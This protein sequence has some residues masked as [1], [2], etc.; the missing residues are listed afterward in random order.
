[1]ATPTN[2]AAA[3]RAANNTQKIALVPGAKVNFRA[4]SARAKWYAHLVA[5][6]GKTAQQFAKAALANPPS[7]PANGKLANK[8]EPPSGW[9]RWFVANGYCKVS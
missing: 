4:G 5:H 7:T 6:N 9:L 1:M 8:C 2:K 3:N